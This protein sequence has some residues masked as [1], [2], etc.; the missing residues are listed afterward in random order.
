MIACG[1]RAC[2]RGL[3]ALSHLAVCR[4]SKSLSEI[5]LP[6]KPSLPLAARDRRSLFPAPTMKRPDLVEQLQKFCVAAEGFVAHLPEVP[7]RPLAGFRV[8]DRTP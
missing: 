6:L 4:F 3:R 8:R 2:S 1:R 7:R 5:P